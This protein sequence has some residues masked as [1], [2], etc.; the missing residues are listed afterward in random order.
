M[1]CILPLAKVRRSNLSRVV[2]RLRKRSVFS[3]ELLE[4]V[5]RIIEGVRAGG[6][7][8]LIEYA[9]KFEN[10]L[11]SIDNLKVREDE[12]E[13]AYKRLD[14]N[15]LRALE[16]SFCQLRL[17]QKR[18]LR[19]RCS[20][21][22]LSG[23]KIDAKLRPIPSVGCYV[24]GGSA[25]YVS[26]VIMTAGLA[27]IAGVPRVVL[28]TPSSSGNDIPD[29]VLAAAKISGVNE[30][31]RVG[32]AQSI[33]ALAYGTESIRPVS[34]IVGPGGKYVTVAKQ[35]ISKDVSIDFLAGPTEI[36][37]FA[38]E[39]CPPIVA[40]WELI[41]QAEHSGE[42]LCVLVTTS[43]KYAKEV[44]EQAKKL[45]LKLERRDLIRSSLQRG[46]TAVCDD[47]ETAFSFLEALSPEHLEI[48]VN[49][50]EEVAEKIGGSGIKLLGLFTPCSLADYVAGTDHVIPTNGHSCSRGP[51]SVLDFVKLDLTLTG[52]RNGL[53]NLLKYIGIMSEIENLPN[54]FLSANSRFEV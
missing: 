10:P 1:R 30:V 49:N 48:M 52:S 4:S 46:L 2:S 6:D 16:F 20:S 34:K 9:R 24:P 14:R 18:I 53:K 32:G 8:A 37:V 3:D 51:L 39:S 17:V 15:I 19:I 36:A 31:Y 47:Y 21:I 43:E 50:P 44:R 25:F 27:K 7:K 40:A 45:I 28:C 22:N 13:D 33:A 35:I 12:I 29:S 26:S 11:L 23:F 42:G 5:S 41:G 54:H 38:D